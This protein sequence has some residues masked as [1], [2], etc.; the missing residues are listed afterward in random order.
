M[1][2]P[3]LA[4]LLLILITPAFA[5]TITYTCP[6]GMAIYDL[7]VVGD[8]PLTASISFTRQ[9]GSTTEGSWTYQ[10]HDFYG[11]PFATRAEITLAGDTKDQVFVTP[12]RLYVNFYTARNLTEI[13]EN[14]FI[15]GAGQTGG[16]NNI[17][18]EKDGI[19]SAIIGFTLTADKD[20]TYTTN[21]ESLDTINANLSSPGITDIK[22]IAYKWFWSALGLLGTLGYWLKFFF[23][24]NIKLIIVL[25]L[26]VPMAFA[27]KASKGNPH[28]FFI[29]YFRTLRS[30]FEF[31]FAVWRML[32]ESI[33]TIRGW[34]RI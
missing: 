8:S 14:R 2:L 10:P 16:I 26:V 23:I 17:A 4:L 1:R 33:G 20:V 13:A 32:L 9:D 3:F 6:T 28:K 18:V 29:S 31:F 5:Q 12:G 15:M 30:F 24:D 11:Y 34:F 25:I 22:N 21:E 7:Q 19:T 27:A